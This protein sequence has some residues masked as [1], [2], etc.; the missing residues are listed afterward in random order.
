MYGCVRPLRYTYDNYRNMVANVDA[1]DSRCG[2]I[3]TIITRDLWL[4]AS[5]L[6]RMAVTRPGSPAAITQVLV[7][8]GNGGPNTGASPPSLQPVKIPAVGALEEGRKGNS[9]SWPMPVGTGVRA[10]FHWDTWL[11]GD[12]LHD[13]HGCWAVPARESTKWQ[14]VR[15]E[16]CI[17]SCE[18]QDESTCMTICIWVY[19]LTQC[20]SNSQHIRTDSA[21]VDWSN[22]VQASSVHV[23]K[24]WGLVRSRSKNFL[25]WTWTRL[26][27][28]SPNWSI[29]WLVESLRTSTIPHHDNE[30]QRI[31]NKVWSC[32]LANLSVAMWQWFI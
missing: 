14:V 23:L 15:G 27:G 25:D 31:I 20:I 11:G 8:W 32:I 26:D 24:N 18:W 22:A 4:V 7:V 17:V 16:M 12:G 5:R 9:K 3:G 13:G 2:C 6:Y 28:S 10:V 29:A 30:R 21:R 19:L 1:S